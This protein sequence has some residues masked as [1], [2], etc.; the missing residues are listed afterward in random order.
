MVETS[1]SVV[2]VVDT[3]VGRW[4]KSES[5]VVIIAGSDDDSALEVILREE[6]KLAVDR[7]ELKVEVECGE[8]LLWT[9]IRY[10]QK[11]RDDADAGR[12]LEDCVF[13]TLG[14]VNDAVVFVVDPGD[15][16]Q[17][18]I[19]AAETEL[20]WYQ[21]SQLREQRADD[22]DESLDGGIGVTI[23]CLTTFQIVGAISC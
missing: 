22:S 21:Q 7:L 18:A 14:D 12:Q 15:A 17:T 13:W 23:H 19:D 5:S 3:C 8:E 9:V 16:T 6:L 2:V 20:T 10:I 11:K 4:G 1:L